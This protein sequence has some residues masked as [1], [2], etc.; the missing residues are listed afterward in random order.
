MLSY[1]IQIGDRY[2]GE[3]KAFLKHGHGTEKFVN[4]DFYV[5]NYVNG[6]PDGYGEYYWANGCQY[7]G[8]F[9]NGLRHGKGVWKKGPGKSD[10]YDGEWVNDKKCG[11]GVYRWISG[12]YYQ[13][14]YFD[15]MRHGYGEMY[16]TDG[17]YYKGQWERGIQHG[18]GELVIP[19]KKPKRGLFQN[20][21]FIGEADDRGESNN[22]EESAEQGSEHGKQFLIAKTTTPKSHL[23]GRSAYS[24]NP[25]SS[26]ISDNELGK[27]ALPEIS[28]GRARSSN[29]TSVRTTPMRERNYSSAEKSK[30]GKQILLSKQELIKWNH[31]KEKLGIEAQK[32]RDLTNPEVCEKVRSIISPPVWKPWGQN[33]LEAKSNERSPDRIY[34]NHYFPALK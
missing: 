9:K 31:M 23:Q 1:L 29:R 5:G 13:G 20:N 8:F 16:W 15:D 21:I 6:K 22:L 28:N 24:R 25:D 17:S 32:Y 26:Y 33:K 12:N 34:S 30:Q 10:S 19:G 14:N 11:Y 4:G 27:G 3:F 7:K 18:E 2:E